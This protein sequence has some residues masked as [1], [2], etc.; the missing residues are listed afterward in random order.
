MALFYFNL[1][2]GHRVTADIE[3]TELRDQA[4]AEQHA[5][6][7]AREIMRNDRLRTLTWRVE[8]GNARHEPC[9]ELLFAA[10]DQYLDHYPLELHEGVTSAAKRVA[11]LNDDIRDVRRSLQK[12]RVTLA[13]VD[14][15]PYLAAVNGI[16]IDA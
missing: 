8:V 14:R 12:L 3:G 9:F 1:N 16:R 11:T 10:V 15:T 6:L 2:D 13:R 5:T 4:A 7:V